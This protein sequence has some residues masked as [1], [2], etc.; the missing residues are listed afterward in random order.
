MIAHAATLKARI[1]FLNIFDGFRTSH[2]LNEVALVKDN[3]ILQML[4]MEAIRAHRERALNPAN[5]FIRG[6]AQ[7]P[8]VFFQSREAANTYINNVPCITQE[9]M[10][11]FAKLTGRQYKIYEYY[12]AE[13]AEKVTVIMGSGAGAVK[14]TVDY[15]N[16]NGQRWV[17]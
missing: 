11:Q 12:G 6:T 15:L 9:T 4:D 16:N 10:D 17:W 1:P 3:V 13:D 7:N 5:P 8:D 2:E 14:E